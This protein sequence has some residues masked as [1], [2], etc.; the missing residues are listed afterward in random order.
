FV[1]SFKESV[2]KDEFDEFV[3]M[4]KAD[5]EGVANAY[6]TLFLAGGADVRVVGADMRQL[7]FKETQGAGETRIC[8]AGGVPP[9][10]GGLSQ[11][12]QSATDPQSDMARLEF[13]DHWARP[14]GR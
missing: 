13:G 12:L 1:A 2:T 3:E 9:I 8:A 11:G 14:Q 4:Y 10:F 5:Q 7:S 6:K